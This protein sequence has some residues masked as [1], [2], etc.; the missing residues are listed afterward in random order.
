MRLSCLQRR[1]QKSSTL[2]NPW[3]R[4]CRLSSHHDDDDGGGGGDDDDDERV[5]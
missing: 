5:I 3:S 2:G 1:Q 4:P